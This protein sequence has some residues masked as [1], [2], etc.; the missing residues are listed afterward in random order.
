MPDHDCPKHGADKNNMITLKIIANNSHFMILPMVHFP[1]YVEKTEDGI[2][3]GIITE[4]QIEERLELPPG[5]RL[6]GGSEI[7]RMKSAN[8]ALN[9]N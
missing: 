4:Y 7:P 6:D 8:A 2:A 3:E 1:P 5:G 9:L